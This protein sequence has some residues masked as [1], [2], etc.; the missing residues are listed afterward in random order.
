MKMVYVAVIIVDNTARLMFL[1]LGAVLIL[2]HLLYA[3]D[4]LWGKKVIRKFKNL[5]LPHG[6]SASYKATMKEML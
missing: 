1:G 6:K 3:Y 4:K 5:S 2:W